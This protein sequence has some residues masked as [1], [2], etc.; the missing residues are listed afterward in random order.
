MCFE[1]FCRF[2]AVV[3]FLKNGNTRTGVLAMR[4]ECAL[5]TMC[6]SLQMGSKICVFLGV[7]G[8]F[9]SDLWQLHLKLLNIVKIH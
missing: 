3:S 7:V 8:R 5:F 4:G 2:A 9:L 6:L 1:N